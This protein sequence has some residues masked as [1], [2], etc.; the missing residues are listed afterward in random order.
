MVIN[1]EYS[2]EGLMMKLK[3]QHIGYLMQKADSLEKTLMLE[4]LKAK[5]EEGNRGWDVWMASPIQWTWTWEKSGRWWG[6]VR[7]NLATEQEVPEHTQTRQIHT[8][9]S[10]LAWIWWVFWLRPLRLYSFACVHSSMWKG[11][12]PNCHHFSVTNYG[13][14]IFDVA[15]HIAKTIKFI[16]V[17]SSLLLV[18]SWLQFY[19]IK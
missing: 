9:L 12:V 5:G 11:K 15:F 6:T 13:K 4:R 19:N 17:V 10:L 3:L 16:Y 18:S 7:H 1:P 2:L 8:W 14:I